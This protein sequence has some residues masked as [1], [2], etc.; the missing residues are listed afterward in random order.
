MFFARH[1]S[2][3][4][5]SPS[6]FRRA[7]SFTC[8]PEPR[9]VVRD[10]RSRITARSKI[11]PRSPGSPLSKIPCHVFCSPLVHPEDSEGPLLSLVIPNPVA[12]F[13]NGGVGPWHERKYN[14]NHR[15]QPSAK[16]AVILNRS[17]GSLSY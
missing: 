17:C 12:L 5:R 15:N 4:T 6:R 9:R 11:Q 2:L 10:R 7:T 1:S 16:L 8:H 14:H 13:A 3:A